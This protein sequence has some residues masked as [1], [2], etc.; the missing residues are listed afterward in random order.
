MSEPKAKPT[1]PIPPYFTTL[2]GELA[3]GGQTASALVDQAGDTPLFVYSTYALTRRI[4]ELRAAM[5]ARL[6][7]HYAM[8]GNPFPPLLE[9][10]AG[11]VDGFD[12]ASGGELQLAMAAGVS[13]NKI[14]FAGPGKRDRELEFAIAHGVTLNCESEGEAARAFAIGDRLGLTPKLAVRVN[15]SFDLK[16]SGMKMGGGAKQFGVDAQRVPDLV[17]AI[18]NAGAEWRGFHIYAGSQALSADAIIAMQAQTLALVTELTEAIGVSPPH[19]NLGGG[20]GIPYFPGDTPLDIAAVGAA[21]GDALNTLPASLSATHFCIEL[22]RYLVGEAGV[23]L[24]RIVD[25]KVSHGEIFLITDGGLHH[26]LAASGN[27]G[28]VIRRNYPVAIA[29][30]F[31]AEPAEVASIVGCL[32][33]PLDLLS[34][35][36]LLPRADVG[37]KVAIFCAGAYGAS[38]SPAN[39]LGQG[40]ALEML[41]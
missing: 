40:A 26:Q 2:N 12:V 30:K 36:P 34:N 21:L 31:D 19:V 35:Q 23:Y 33:T 41:V 32:C 24:C 11:R 25:R 7:L 20:F 4:A 16:G 10:M 9:W 5:P 8:K 27:F 3:I 1:G 38:A 14:S 28:T 6:A 13:P 29:N 22:G 18:I 15:P 39:F 37:D 17:R